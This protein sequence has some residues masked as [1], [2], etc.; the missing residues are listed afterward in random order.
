MASTRGAAASA[1]P[2][3]A[4][5]RRNST[6]R[7]RLISAESVFVARSLA[8]GFAVLAA[9]AAPAVARAGLVSMHVV[10]VGGRSLADAQPAHFN[11][12]AA[13]WSGGGGVLYRV[14]RRAGWSSWNPAPSDDPD[15]TGAADG[16]EFRTRGR[17]VHLRAFELWSRV[18]KSPARS[19]SEASSPQIVMRS[20][21]E[22]DEKIVRAKPLIAKTLKLAIVHH[23]VSINNY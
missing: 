10:D 21:W 4:K 8:A 17:V 9:L 18:T 3:S 22:A 15:W 19:L 2:G 23:T 1:F 20:Q 7:R 16:V 11:M 14:H 13:K 5:A 6:V 12:L